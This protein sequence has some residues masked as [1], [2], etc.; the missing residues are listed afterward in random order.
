MT[1][2][3]ATSQIERSGAI[4]ADGAANLTENRGGRS[5]FQLCAT[6]SASRAPGFDVLYGRDIDRGSHLSR[7]GR[8]RRRQ[9]PAAKQILKHYSHIRMEAKRRAVEALEAG[10]GRA[11]ARILH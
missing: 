3:I 9:A 1:L 8:P 5:P 10:G 11:K 4:R 2:F 7:A 6:L